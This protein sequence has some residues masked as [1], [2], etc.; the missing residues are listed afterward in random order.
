MRLIGVWCPTIKK[1][2]LYITSTT[3]SE[4]S[5]DVAPAVYAMRWEIELMFRELKMQLRME[6]MPSGNKAVTECLLY[7][8]LLALALG[9]QLHRALQ[10]RWAR[11]SSAARTRPMERFTAVMHALMPLLL[12]LLLAPPQHRNALERRLRLTLDREAPDPNRKRILLTQRAQ[13]GI[14]GPR[15]AAA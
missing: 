14:L 2:R 12:D 11:T 15:S 4:L 9:R 10:D 8:S 1:H 7:A 6:D 13:L 5:A 3:P